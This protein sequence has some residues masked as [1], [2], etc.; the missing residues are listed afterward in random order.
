[1]RKPSI[2]H[3]RLAIDGGVPVRASN[4]PYG[5]QA[6]EEEDIESVIQVLRSDWITTGPNV[7]EFEEAVASYV[8]ARFAVAFSSGTTA[9]HGAA[10]A[11]GLG[12]GDEAI[13]T[14]MT[15]C[16]TANCV[17]YM[18][19]SPVFADICPDTLNID[20][21]QVAKRNFTIWSDGSGKSHRSR[22]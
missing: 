1:M 12:P 19:A 2:L 4:L 10:F 11:A 8:G 6:I 9:L 21:A 3:Q 14:P 16:A 18:G 20:T 7:Q 22:L 17:L 5:H 13:T 15:F